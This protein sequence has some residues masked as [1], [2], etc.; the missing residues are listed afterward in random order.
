MAVRSKLRLPWKRE[1]RDT[2]QVLLYTRPGCHLCDEARG[3]V[4]AIARA[5]GTTVDLVEVD[6]TTDAV[7]VERYGI[8]I[9]V[10]VVDG[11]GELAAPIRERDV[12]RALR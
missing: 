2:H 12:R 1:T 3:L 8:R 6:I 7:L 4:L 5:T 9:P 10:L 11:N